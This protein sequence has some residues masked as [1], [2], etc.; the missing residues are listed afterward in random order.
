MK[1]NVNEVHGERAPN[2]RSTVSRVVARYQKTG[3]FN[4]LSRCGRPKIKDETKLNA[5]ITLRE[6]PHTT[7][8]KVA[9]Q[10]N[11]NQAFIAKFVEKVNFHPYTS[12]MS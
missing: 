11:V 6:N 4:D 12:F 10:E 8:A 5:L 2:S 1:K 7:T 9:R 3:D